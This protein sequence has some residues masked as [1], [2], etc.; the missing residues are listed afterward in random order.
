MRIKFAK[1]QPNSETDKVTK[2]CTLR[3]VSSSNNGGTAI[4]DL[5]LEL[6]DSVATI[7]ETM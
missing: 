5:S 7:G 6:I 4:R 1:L 3:T 2:G